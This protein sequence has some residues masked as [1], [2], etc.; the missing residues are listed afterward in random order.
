MNAVQLLYD[1]LAHDIISFSRSFDFVFEELDLK[2]Y[3][4]TC[5]HGPKFAHPSGLL[6]I[7]HHDLHCKLSVNFRCSHQAW[8]CANLNAWFLR[9]CL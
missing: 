1:P 5:A 6:C 3:W 8:L 4:A 7:S 2:A 9:V